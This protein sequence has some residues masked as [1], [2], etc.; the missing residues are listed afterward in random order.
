MQISELIKQAADFYN[1][2]DYKSALKCAEKILKIDKENPDALVIKGNIYYQKHRFSDSLNCYLDA[3]K[4]DSQH[5]IALLNIANTYFELKDY[6]ESYRVAQQ[7][8]TLD[9]H[10]KTALTILGNS[11]LELEKY[12]EG[13]RAFLEILETDSNDAWSYNSLSKIYQKT[14]DDERALAYGWKAVEV[15]AGDKN[16]HINFGYLLYEI[17]NDLARVY[18]Q[19]WLEKYGQDLVVNHMGNAIL[20]NAKIARAESEYVREIFDAF[21]DDFEEVLNGL[22]YRAPQIIADEMKQIFTPHLFHKM[23]ILDAGC[24]TGFC[25]EFLKKYSK[26][27]GLYGVD[28]SEKMIEKAATKKVYDKLIRAD[29]EDF[30][31]ENKK[32]FDLIISADVFT[33]LGDL[34]KIIEGCFKSLDK[35]GRILFTV[36]ANKIN[37]ENYYLHASG[38]FLHHR[39]YIE[40]LLQK[41]GF[42]IEKTDEKILRREGE[43]MVSGYIFRAIKKA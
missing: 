9:S 28:I 1:G 24:G 42:I 29:L 4:K 20:H 17:G 21:A 33:Y 2:E 36:S 31:S 30:F 39:K 38:R 5:Q 37:E 40:N 16:Q 22:E 41:N 35:N 6:E 27:K 8:L 7:L 13:K 14:E 23:S 15:S 34:Q 26:F 12:D 32:K 3:I 18:A 43:N 11:A 10:N 25:G 19:K